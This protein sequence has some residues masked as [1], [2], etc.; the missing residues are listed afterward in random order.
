MGDSFNHTGNIPFSISV[1]DPDA[2]DRI[3]SISLYQNGLL[4]ESVYAD[5]ISLTWEPVIT[6]PVG[7]N[8]YFVEVHEMDGN[9]AYTSPI[10]I[11]CVDGAI[12]SPIPLVPTDE[13]VL[14][15]L[16]PR[17]YWQSTGKE[18]RYILQYSKSVDFPNNPLTTTIRN[19]TGTSYTPEA[20]LEDTTRYY[21]KVAAAGGGVSTTYSGI[22][23]FFTN[24]GALFTTGSEIRLTTS[25][26]E[27][28]HPFLIQTSHGLWLFWDS[29]QAEK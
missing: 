3:G 26:S 9:R 14:T 27:D 2:N 5:T 23:K 13:A 12:Y 29:T 18:N 10:W 8:Y 19:I 21:W 28:T 4:V 17:F 16:I 24:K 1:N 11:D 20:Y 6:P 22:R 7:K 15:I 25:S